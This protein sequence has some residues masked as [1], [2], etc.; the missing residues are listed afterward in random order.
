[1]AFQRTKRVYG[2]IAVIPILLFLAA[3][4]SRGRYRTDVRSVEHA[5]EVQETVYDLQQTLADAETGRRGFV[6]TGDA[7]YLAPVEAAVARVPQLVQ[8]LNELTRDNPSQQEIVRVLDRLVNERAGFLKQTAE[9][10]RTSNDKLQALEERGGLEV[11]VQLHDVA[12]G[13][14]AEENRLLRTRQQASAAADMW[15]GF[16][17]GAGVAATIVLLLWSYRVVERYAAERDRAA[18]AALAANQD[19]QEHMAKVDRLNRDLEERVRARTASLERSNSD[20][21]QFALVASHDLKEPLRMITSYTTLLEESSRERLTPDER[22]FLSFAAEGTRRMQALIND[23][24]VYTQAGAQDPA[25]TPAKL[26]D[27]LEQARYSLLES[28]RETAAEIVAEPLPEAEVD[29]LKMSLVF[30]NL[31]SNAIKFRRPGEKPRIHVRAELQGSEWRIAVRDEGI[32]F[33]QQYADKIFAAFKRLH[34]RGEYPGTGIGLAICKRIVEGHGGRIWAES[35][36]DS[37]ATFYFTLPATD[38]STRLE[39]ERSDATVAASD[40]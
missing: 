9:I 29:P 5:R 25:R 21:Q 16:L 22:K 36:G 31:F 32:G 17:F 4:W 37:G 18:L 11:S 12:D 8:Q 13:M 40:R 27:V 23:L 34:S 19:L 3:V 26:N 38:I 10:G 35:R 6:I 39:T 1:M 24:L 14:I 30:Q 2:W 33:D 28:I 20:L 15:M 7:G